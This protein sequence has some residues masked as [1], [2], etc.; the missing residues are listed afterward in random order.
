MCKK[1]FYREK[2]VISKHNY[3]SQSCAAIVNNQRYPKWPARYCKIC[4]KVVKREGTPYCSIECGKAGRFKYTKEE[5]LGL[6]RKYHK[7]TGRIPAK[8]EVS[9]LTNRAI[10][11]FD[12][13]NNVILAAG[14]TPNRSHDNRMYKRA[15]TK[16]E[17]G[18]LCDSISE[19]LI[20]NWLAKN[21][22][23]HE[24]DIPYPS[25]N[26]KADW[27]IKNNKVFVEY[28]G[29]AKDSPR[30]DRS[31]RKK[32]KLCDKFKIKLIE[33][34]PQDLYPEINIDSKLRFLQKGRIRN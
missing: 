26:H 12:S 3:C 29:L 33:I 27:G 7:E 2:H 14:F 17:D 19:A 16:A 31:V 34:Y 10:N 1:E 21:K 25:T 20:D 5:I 6:I 11:L 30:Y 8:R 4:K 9:E 18:H 23:P 22:I 32:K 15:M 24:R 13:W 28:F